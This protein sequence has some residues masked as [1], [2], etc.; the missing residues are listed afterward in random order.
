MTARI[1]RCKLPA[2]TILSLLAFAASAY[3]QA[4][5]PSPR[6]TSIYP[7]GGKAGTTVDVTV[8][9]ADLEGPQT[10]LF[11][12]A[13]SKP[14]GIKASGNKFTLT[15]PAD[16]AAGTFD[17]RFVGRFGIS[18]PRVFQISGLNLIEAS[19]KNLKAADA[20]PIQPDC[21]I[22]G[23]FKSA[24]PHWFSFNAKKDQR[25]CAIF[26]GGTFDTKIAMS[27]TILDDQAR[28]VARMRDGFL[29]F[30]SP[31]DGTYHLRIHDLMFG[32]GDDYGYRVTFT[33][34][35]VVYCAGKEIV[36]G[37]NL[38]NGEVQS[39]LSVADRAPLE[40]AKADAATVQK[41]IANSPLAP[42]L[43][44]ADP[45]PITAGKPTAIQA[46][47][48]YV[49]WFDADGAPALFDLAYKNG[50]SFVIEVASQ[51][52]GFATD[53]NLLIETV[54]KDD[55][56][57]ETIALQAD[58]ND[59]PSSVP[60]PSLSLPDLDP[61]YAYEAKSDGIFRLSLTDPLNAA[62]GRRHPFAL[63]IRKT[64]T[65]SL[66][67]AVAL[68]PSL[69]AAA[70]AYEVT[71]TN[72]WRNGIAAIE[73]WVPGRTSSSPAMP[74]TLPS[75]PAGLAVLPGFIGK[76]RS[77]GYIGFQAAADAPTA[78]LNLTEI[79]YSASVTWPVK[80]PN[81][82]TLYTRIA[83]APAI[84]V[85]DR[86]A[87]ALVRTAPESTFEGLVDGKVEISLDVV[88]SPDF[89]DALKLKV[90]GLI[91]ATKAPEASIAAKATNGKLTLDLKALKL[92]PGEYGFIL[93]GPAKMKISRALEE[94]AAANAT[95][96]QSADARE[97]AAKELAAAA[98]AA[99]GA[100][101]ADKAAKD[102][103]VKT[104]TEKLKKADKTK[105]DTAAAAKAL[106]AKDAP[107]EATFVVWSNP[108]KLIVKEAAKKQ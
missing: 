22:Q 58:V 73:V 75:A 66:S 1:P 17:V 19:G 94:V 29:D 40:R 34:A 51:K 108:A 15:L 64:G 86:A 27:G 61:V 96:K 80:D 46:D 26:H 67:N 59:A 99:K 35:P 3:A 82:E 77:I 42:I 100:T 48:T 85:V 12:P 102:A 98:A 68:Y 76:G 4:T 8:K 74:L 69:P 84:G 60:G 107:K 43:L 56:G 6:L 90:L 23:V 97:A 52:L 11:T 20:Q 9:G 65:N 57:I 33:A 50:D 44:P 13:P 36:Y 103:A 41:W 70:K 81:R 28:E 45:Q 78:A 32:S 5:F 49:A 63:S 25:L 37:W 72:V 2:C 79:P 14:I 106:A 87:P 101:P 95:A 21:A 18:N 83:G 24:A 88:R 47:Q 38:P 16:I 7:L 10:L 55:K 30:V 54:K 39:D 53:P 71:S 104:A 62:N 91:D 105:T 89:T 93:Q 92:A 31:K